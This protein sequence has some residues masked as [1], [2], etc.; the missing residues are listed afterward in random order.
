MRRNHHRLATWVLA[1]W[2]AAA[3]GT[4]SSVPANAA[5]DIQ[6]HVYIED[7]QAAA[8]LNGKTIYYFIYFARQTASMRMRFETF[9]NPL[10]IEQLK[11]F[12]CC[13]VDASV[14]ANQAFVERY[15]TGG[16][17]DRKE[18]MRVG[19]MP[20]NLF[21]D[22]QGKEHFLQ[23]GYVAADAFV[24]MVQRVLRLVELKGVVVASPNDASAH[25]ELAK[26]MVQLDLTTKTAF[27]TILPSLERAKALD[28]D[29]KAGVAEEATLW[30]LILQTA[31]DPAKSHEQFLQFLKDYPGTKHIATAT[32]FAASAL[33]MQSED[34][35]AA[36]DEKGADGK[37]RQAMKMLAPFKV[38]EGD[39]SVWATS[40]FAIQAL[41]LEG[42]IGEQ[43]GV[44]K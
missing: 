14:K 27:A 44:Y 33:V 39:T 42:A 5:N 3:A 43:L 1:G 17:Q 34:L 18:G 22:A 11:Q 13:A 40:E 6:W 31:D 36:K 16:F 35:R 32:F 24:P 30:L 28:P 7:A 25:L 19:H 23:H 26:V 41:R 10:V 20:A 9:K 12:E 21:A 15:G 29:N 37:L 4:L 38:K 8:R 2:M